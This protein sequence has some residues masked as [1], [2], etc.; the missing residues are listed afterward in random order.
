MKQ[1]RWPAFSFTFLVLIALMWQ[2]CAQYELINPLWFPSPLDTLR[3]LQSLVLS[4]EMIVSVAETLRRMIT[5]FLIA[6]VAG[7]LAGGAIASSD[8][9][10]KLLEPTVEFLR[11]LPA[12]ALVPVVILVLG[13]SERMIIVVV[14]LGSIW[15][16]LLASIHGF[17]SL[18]PRLLEVAAVLQMA[19]LARAI[20]MQLPNALPHIF[21]GVRVSISIALI[22]TVAAEMLS[23]Q[24]GVGY[25]MLMGARS[26]QSTEVFSGILVLGVIGL[27][28]NALLTRLE[29]FFVS[30]P[31]DSQAAN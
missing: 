15:P 12:S 23:S 16:I 21:S 5:G 25:L 1:L 27:V 20:K 13:Y 18:D 19:P 24:P 3:R 31:I 28:T 4:G 22:V 10:R 7:V 8:L 2:L 30:W 11:P 17:R 14:I 9:L 6:C 29:I 26:F